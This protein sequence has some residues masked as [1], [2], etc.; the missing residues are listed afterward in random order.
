MLNTYTKKL[1]EDKV[2]KSE[3]F[4]EVKEAIKKFC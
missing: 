2:N 4:T 3:I 1:E